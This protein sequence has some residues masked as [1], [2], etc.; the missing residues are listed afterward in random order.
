MG[1]QWQLYK[2]GYIGGTNEMG[3][4]WAQ[5]QMFT[6]GHQWD[7]VP[8]SYNKVLGGNEL[9][10]Q[11]KGDQWDGGPMRGGTSERIPLIRDGSKSTV[12]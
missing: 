8:M 9:G 11:W 12:V 10:D 4:Q 2:Q 3:D 6:S 1:D 5:I 7:G